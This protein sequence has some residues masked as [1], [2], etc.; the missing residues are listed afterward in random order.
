VSTTTATSGRAVQVAAGLAERWV[1]CYTVWVGAEAAE[2]R[3]AEIASDVWEH[4]AHETATGAPAWLVAWSIV[5]RVVGGVPADVGWVH[6]QRTA[7][8]GRPHH[9]E[10]DPMSILSSVARWWWV[11]GALLV[12]AFYVVI[13]V[14][15]LSEPGMPY[16]DGAIVAGAAALVILAGAAVRS[17][18]PRLGAILILI[19]TVPATMA[20]WFPGVLAVAAAVSIGAIAEAARLTVGDGVARIAA[21]VALVA[22]ALSLLAPFALGFSI[23][24]AVLGA[25]AVVGL[26]VTS[27]RRPAP[28]AIA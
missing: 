16:L 7:A 25:V 12:A 17:R 10:A 27:R 11:A 1:G 4:R 5:A 6:T 3:C 2:R 23:G 26:L 15:N 20:F 19:G 24:W 18:Q 21:A 28:D 22:L 8:R 13:V 9:G 14:S